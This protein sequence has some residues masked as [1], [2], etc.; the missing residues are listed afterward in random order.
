MMHEPLPFDA[1]AIS[2]LVA[3]LAHYLIARD[4]RLAVAESCTGG[5]IAVACTERAGSSVWFDQG[6]VTYSNEAKVE[7]LGVDER[8][9]E[10]QGAVSAPVVEAMLSGALACSRA[11]WAIA[12]SGVA[13]PG[14]GSVEKPV[15]TVYIGWAERGDGAH[16]QRFN[17]D[18]DRAAIR[19]AS[20]VEGLRGL[21]ERL[22]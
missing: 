19:R 16:A 15:G 1:D 5:L 21:V 12:V 4:Q 14:G 8:L 17:F 11:H 3:D 6:F 7:T 18:G 20:V 2:K 13:G 10:S 22:A 9:I